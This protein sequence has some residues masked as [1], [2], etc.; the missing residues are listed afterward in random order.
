MG[1]IVEDETGRQA[2]SV[3]DTGYMR[4]GAGLCGPVEP[5]VPLD[6]EW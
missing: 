5:V 2:G 3:G 4:Y 1:A 6:G